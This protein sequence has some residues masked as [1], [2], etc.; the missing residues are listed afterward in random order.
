MTQHTLSIESPT[1]FQKYN[2]EQDLA[3][4]CWNQIYKTE[5]NRQFKKQVQLKD[6]KC[7][8]KFSIISP[9]NVVYFKPTIKQFSIS[10]SKTLPE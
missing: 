1:S 6:P 2:D 7:N 9:K 8:N 3:D 10:P 5:D 4:N